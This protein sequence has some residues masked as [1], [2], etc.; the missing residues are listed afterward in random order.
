MRAAIFLL[1]TSLSVFCMAYFVK[2]AIPVRKP[3]QYALLITGILETV[4]ILTRWAVPENY[5]YI[6]MFIYPC[7]FLLLFFYVDPGSYFRA[8]IIQMVLCVIPIVA[9]GVLA[10]LVLPIG[11]ALGAGPEAFTDWDGRYYILMT[12]LANGFSCGAEWGAAHL[13]R[14]LLSP[15]RESRMVLCLLPIPITQVILITVFV[16]LFFS[17]YSF[18]V[19]VFFLFLGI[20]LSLAA[21]AVC[22]L[23]YRNYT[24]AQLTTQQLQ[25]AKHQLEIQADHYGKLQRDI[26]MINQIR[27][28]LKN[29]LQAAYYLLQHGNSEEVEQQLDLLSEQLSRQVGSRFCENLMVDAVLSEK[30][31]LCREKN[32]RLEVSALVP[33]KT[34]VENTYLCSAFSNLL[35][36]SIHGV[37][38]SEEPQGPIELSTDLQEDYLVIRCSNPAKPPKEEK[39]QS[40]LREHG[41]GQ[42]ILAQIAQLGEGHFQS[43]YENGVFQS[44]LVLKR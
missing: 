26:L 17:W 18:G 42:Q 11:T 7:A 12:L 19:A 5:S 3:L 14:T 23:G 39:N 6:L 24:R 21:D 31:E 28:D 33:Q 34:S 10:A 8:F 38:E 29:Q 36:N 43:D 40:L 44:V 32:I 41:L 4:C 30:A 15:T 35:D 13:L 16:N 22:I 1:M 9:C 27:H 2:I 20:G 25:E 37:L